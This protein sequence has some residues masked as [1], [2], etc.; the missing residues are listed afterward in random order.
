MTRLAER[1]L[2]SSTLPIVVLLESAEGDLF[3]TVRRRHLEY[4]D[5]SIPFSQA[6][7]DFVACTVKPLIDNQF[8]TNATDSYTIGASLGGEYLVY[9]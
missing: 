6:H 9:Y 4:G 8:R 1:G 5:I 7:A 3:P 2:I